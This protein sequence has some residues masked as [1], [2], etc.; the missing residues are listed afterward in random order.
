[1]KTKRIL[2]LMLA[3]LLCIGVL[4]TSA[5]A[6]DDPTGFGIRDM[7]YEAAVIAVPAMNK[8]FDAANILAGAVE[9]W[10]PLDGARYTDLPYGDAIFIDQLFAQWAVILDKDSH[11]LMT[12]EKEIA[13]LKKVYTHNRLEETAKG[14]SVWLNGMLPEREKTFN[15]HIGGMTAEEKE[16]EFGAETC[17]KFPDEYWSCGYHALSAWVSPQMVMASLFGYFGMEEESTDVFGNFAK[18]V[19]RNIVAVGEYNRSIDKELNLVALQQEPGK[20]TPRFPPYPRYKSSWEYL[21]C[22]LGITMDFDTITLA[23][24]KSV[25]VAVTDVELAGTR[26]TVTVEPNWTRCLVDGVEADP[27]ISRDRTCVSLA[28]VK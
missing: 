5:F 16:A 26:L 4:A 21:I 13:A 23:P 11:G 20:D 15:I 14:Y 24:F 10:S 28:F 27:V 6:A 22:L 3:A 25:A 2:S 8:V 7:S 17:A 12:M 9:V 18:G 1:M 19:G